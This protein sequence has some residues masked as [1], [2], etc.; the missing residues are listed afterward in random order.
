M[1]L[2]NHF[3]LSIICFVVQI[4]IRMPLDSYSRMSD[5]LCN[6]S[7]SSMFNK[8]CV[9]TVIH[10][11]WVSPHIISLNWVLTRKHLAVTLSTTDPPY[12]HFIKAND[13]TASQV[14]IQSCI[15]KAQCKVNYSAGKAWQR[16]MNKC[17]SR[18]PWS[19]WA[20]VLNLREHCSHES[21]KR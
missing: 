9:F 11:T 7:Y 3:N 21:K 14:R 10:K 6:K 2:T 17:V 5:C 16:L 1:S 12:V 13:V 18:K 19:C 20:I 4:K 8:W 15:N